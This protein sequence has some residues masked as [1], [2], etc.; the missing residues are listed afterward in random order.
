MSRIYRHKPHSPIRVALVRWSV[1]AASAGVWGLSPLAAAHADAEPP[2]AAPPSVLETP[3]AQTALPNPFTPEAIDLLSLDLRRDEPSGARRA[4][5]EAIASHPNPPLD[6]LPALARALELAQD[7]RET[8]AILSALARYPTTDSI[9]AVLT[10]LDRTE[11]PAAALHHA[12]RSAIALQIARPELITDEPRFAEWAD[13]FRGATERERR[14]E[15][16]MAHARRI[17]QLDAELDRANARL[18]D[19]YRRLFA[20]TPDDGRSALL[21]ELMRADQTN[22]RILG[23]ELATR[24][25]LNAKP[26]G[27][28]VAEAA[29]LG[30]AHPD[31]SVRAASAVL[32]DRLNLE[33]H[34][35]PCASAFTLERDPLAA[36]AMMRYLS[37]HPGAEIAEPALRWLAQ[38]GPV[39]DASTELVLA[40]LRTGMLDQDQ[41][42]AVRE[43]LHAF[44]PTQM[45]PQSVALLNELGEQERIVPLLEAP[46][47]RVAAAAAAALGASGE[48]LALVLD[49]ALSRPELFEPAC[50]ALMRHRPDAAGFADAASLN[51][52]N[53]Q[54]K[55]DVLAEFADVLAPAALLDVAQQTEDLPTRERY[56]RRAAPP[57]FLASD[58]SDA[59]RRRLVDLLVRT[60]I[61]LSDP[62]GA[63]AVLENLPPSRDDQENTACLLSRIHCL[64]WLNR[65]D[66]AESLTTQHIV[67]PAAWLSGLESAMTLPHAPKVIQRIRTIFAGQLSPD[68]IKRLEHLSITLQEQPPPDA[69]PAA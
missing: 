15:I 9:F 4:A 50:R 10:C 18:L 42:A 31:A 3:G 59:T 60:R 16:A 57:E 38:K 55:R 68:Q 12:V 58:P 32:V 1:W 14:A 24:T 53:P 17:E 8:A 5:A 47:A 26:V 64:V 34:A 20:A 29:V 51:A 67:P 21:S 41:A 25:I 7:T 62:A 65:L 40:L 2:V 56:L 44:T 35:D 45:T 66:D 33:E 49:A 69:P 63:L 61:E 37:R 36:A 27:P 28:R 30:L 13:W 39:I 46:D 22:I 48:Q 23:I 43:Q 11:T 6:L 19:V 52:P 54:I